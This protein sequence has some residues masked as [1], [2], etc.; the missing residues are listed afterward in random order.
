MLLFLPTMSLDFIPSKRKNPSAKVIKIMEIIA[1]FLIFLL[2]GKNIFVIVRQ[3]G[4]K[5][6]GLISTIVD[7]GVGKTVCLIY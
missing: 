3:K 2:L 7:C 4:D 1:V 5:M 6:V